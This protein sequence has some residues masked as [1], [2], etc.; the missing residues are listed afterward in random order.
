MCRCPGRSPVIIASTNSPFDQNRLAKNLRQNHCALAGLYHVMP[1]Y[2]ICPRQHGQSAPR[3]TN[4]RPIDAGCLD[5]RSWARPFLPGS[6]V[7]RRW[8]EQPRRPN[9]LLQFP[10]QT[11]HC[12][13]GAK[14]ARKSETTGS[15][16]CTGTDGGCAAM[17]RHP[18]LGHGIDDV[19]G[20][21]TPR[22]TM[23]ANSDPAEG[24]GVPRSAHATIWENTS[25]SSN[26]G[27]SVSEYVP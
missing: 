17:Q 9:S 27:S 20:G 1:E 23:P 6:P 14:N 2:R 21:R 16:G 3:F 18:M 25:T 7:A 12:V 24:Q 11:N 10:S 15:T 13:Q 4:R 26:S 22:P 5:G 8:P 19:I